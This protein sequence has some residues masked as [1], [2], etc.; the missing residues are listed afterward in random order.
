MVEGLHI[1]IGLFAYVSLTFAGN[2]YMVADLE[3]HPKPVQRPHPPILIGG[4]GKRLLMVAAREATIVGFTPRF[5]TDGG[6]ADVTDAAPEA[7]MEKLGW[8]R[9]AAG[10]RF[11]EL[12]LN[13]LV[14]V[15]MV[16]EDREQV[17]QF[18]A[19]TMA[20][21]MG[22]TVEHALQVPYVLLGTVDQI[23]DDLL[24]PRAPYGISCI[25]LFDTH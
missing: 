10:N 17:A 13:I 1:I 19:A 9:Q 12:E 23:C 8:V 4:G 6:G 25:T 7:L 24:A 15:V 16:T 22:V 20:P 18:I 11:D 14:A 2:Y 3:G 21:N 5:R